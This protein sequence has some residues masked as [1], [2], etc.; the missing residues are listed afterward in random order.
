MIAAALAAIAL[1]PGS[2]AP[3]HYD[4]LGPIRDV[5]VHWQSYQP[6]N[7]F[8]I[9]PATDE[10]TPDGTGATVGGANPACR[11]SGFSRTAKGL[12]I[13]HVPTPTLCPGCRRLFIDFS[14]IP[15]QDPPGRYYPRGHV[16]Y[17][18]ESVNNTY[19]LDPIDHSPN[20]KNF[21]NDELLAPNG[22]AQDRIIG[23]L[24][25]HQALGYTTDTLNF[26][27]TK[28]QGLCY[29]GPWYVGRTGRRIDGVYFDVDVAD[30][31][32][33][34]GGAETNDIDYVGGFNARRGALG[35]RT[36]GCVDWW[37]YSTS[38]VDPF[39]SVR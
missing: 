26:I 17:R 5:T 7:T 22:S 13:I 36:R 1:A 14:K 9:K 39:A 3:F 16:F 4:A 33:L 30:A 34:P 20:T 10:Y 19:T 11:G 23:A 24:D 38:T 37:A 21:T 31:T 8:C 28:I 6:A 32:A 15:R 27:H 25:L 18:L 12:V 35:T 29:A 2:A